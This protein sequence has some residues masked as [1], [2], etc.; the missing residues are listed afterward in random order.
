MGVMKYQITGNSAV[1]PAV[2]SVFE[3]ETVAYD[4][5]LTLVILAIWSASLTQFTIVSTAKIQR[6]GDEQVHFN[7]N[8]NLKSY[9]FSE[10]LHQW[11]SLRPD[12]LLFVLAISRSPAIYVWYFLTLL[13]INRGLYD[14]G[15]D[16]Q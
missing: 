3:E 7:S 6:P 16:Q 5:T 13:K 9:I 2:F 8:L 10:G 4:H 11:N 1:Y 15:T 12:V 14:R